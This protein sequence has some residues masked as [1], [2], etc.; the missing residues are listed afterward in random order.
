MPCTQ[1]G[2]ESTCCQDSITPSGPGLE[3][4]KPNENIFAQRQLAPG[5]LISPV[6]CIRL[7]SNIVQHADKKM[8]WDSLHKYK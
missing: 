8:L 4:S 2:K 1:R 7:Y 3:P 5:Q 6:S